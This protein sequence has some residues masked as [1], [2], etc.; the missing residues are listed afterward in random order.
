MIFRNRVEPGA[1]PWQCLKA[2][3]SF[4]KST[5]QAIGNDPDEINLGRGW[6]PATI[7]CGR[8]AP[9]QTGFG[10]RSN[11][12]MPMVFGDKRGV[13]GTIASPSGQ[14]NVGTPQV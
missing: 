2:L 14:L 4:L 6:H 10:L 5:E 7:A 1:Q 11:T 8:N 3:S 9:S 13:T 12:F